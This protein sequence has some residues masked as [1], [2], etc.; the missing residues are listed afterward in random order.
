MVKI[1]PDVPPHIAA[2][3]KKFYIDTDAEDHDEYLSNYEPD[4]TFNVI[5]PR[6][7]HDAIRAGRLW[8][9]KNRGKD[10]IH[11]V[12]HVWCSEPNVAWVIG[13]NDFTR[14]NDGVF[15]NVPFITRMTF[16]GDKNNLK[17]KDYYAW[18][19]SL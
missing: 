17:L 14:A 3:V 16:N 1:D 12:F 7:G 15:V 4:A 8:S 2:F 18:V 11:R 5:S 10:Q 6:Q 9:F 13:D 19:V